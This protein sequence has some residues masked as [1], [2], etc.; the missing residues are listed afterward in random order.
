MLNVFK[1]LN[2]VVWSKPLVYG[3]LITGVLFT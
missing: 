2:E 3:L 1:F